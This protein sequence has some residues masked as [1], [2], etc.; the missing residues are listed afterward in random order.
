MKYKDIKEII[1]NLLHTLKQQTTTL[2]NN[3]Y[4]DIFDKSIKL[5]NFLKKNNAY[6]EF[7]K[8][9]DLNYY[10]KCTSTLE[11]NV[12]FINAFSWI[13]SYLN[14]DK[15]WSDLSNKWN[16][17]K[18]IS[19]DMNWLIH[20]KEKLYRLKNNFKDYEFTAEFEG[21]ILKE[22]DNQYIGYYK[23]TNENIITTI[24]DK[25][26][27]SIH[28][29]EYN[30]T[31]Y[32]KEWFETDTHW[33]MTKENNT[34]FNPKR[35]FKIVWTEEMKNSFKESGWRFATTEEIKHLKLKD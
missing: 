4:A 27:N 7:V 9:F 25:K 14:D 22:I 13:S 24:W 20:E 30:L 33:I 18:H 23:S 12:N 3:K 28:N 6:D 35:K 32:N 10:K 5:S 2:K 8:N 34:S 17:L 1:E 29:T 11:E 31:P 15:D 16:K 21:E 26:G 19:Y